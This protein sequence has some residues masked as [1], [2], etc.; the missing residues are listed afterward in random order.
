MPSVG[1]I[2]LPWG[3]STESL[4]MVSAKT[5][6]DPDFYKRYYDLVGNE[7]GLKPKAK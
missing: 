2:S 5:I 7:L 6:S 4:V 3:G 1:S